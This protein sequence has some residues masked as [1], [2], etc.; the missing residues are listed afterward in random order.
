MITYHSKKTVLENL[1]GPVNKLLVLI[2]LAQKSSI[3]PVLINLEKQGFKYGPLLFIY[4][5]TSFAD[6]E[7][8][9]ESAL[10]C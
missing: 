2:A 7:G 1:F 10:L 6:S 5:H 3:N 4:I 8:S 9:V